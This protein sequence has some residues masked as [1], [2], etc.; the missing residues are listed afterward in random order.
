MSLTEIP[1]TD[2]AKCLMGC[3]MKGLGMV[4][5]KNYLKTEYSTFI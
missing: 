1:N 4:I 3:A 2:G 5:S